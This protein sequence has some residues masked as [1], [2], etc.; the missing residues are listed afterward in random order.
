MVIFNTIILTSGHHDQGGYKIYRQGEQTIPQ[1]NSAIK[2]FLAKILYGFTS[3]VLINIS[4][5]ALFVQ[6]HLLIDLHYFAD[7]V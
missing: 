2:S 7:H 5:E 4:F 6:R 1:V 3:N